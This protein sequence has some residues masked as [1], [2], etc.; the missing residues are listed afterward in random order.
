VFH[1]LLATFGVYRLARHFGASI[2]GAFVAGALW[3]ASGPFV[4]LV[5]LW[6][7]YAGTAWIPWVFLTVVRALE[8][9]AAADRRGRPGAGPPDRG[10]VGRPL[11][12][13]APRD[14]LLRRRLPARLACPFAL[15]NRRLSAQAPRSWPSDGL[16]AALWMT[17]LELI[18][19]TP[20]WSLPAGIRT[21]WSV[22]PLGALQ[23][24]LPRPLDR[25]GA[26][27]ALR[28]ALFESREPFLF[29]LYL[30]L[31]CLALI[32]G[33]LALQPSAIKRYWLG[34]AAAVLLI[35]LGRHFRPL[36]PRGPRSFR[37]CASCAIP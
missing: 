5:D 22:H 20:R 15:A 28:E 6:H 32:A 12:H 7:H 16:S 17:A 3:T 23:H 30:G 21:Y 2:A 25:R 35:A 10:R 27:A 18:T 31:P 29:S 11:R 4:S 19:R 26:L 8:R 36:R 37:P 14:R 13:D 9:P 1:S 33:G 24:P 34:F